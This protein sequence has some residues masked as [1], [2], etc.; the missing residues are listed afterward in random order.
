MN[1]YKSYVWQHY[2]GSVR[3]RLDEN[4][5]EHIVVW[6]EHGIYLFLLSTAILQTAV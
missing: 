1:R 6:N 4:S 2:A 3:P 5:S